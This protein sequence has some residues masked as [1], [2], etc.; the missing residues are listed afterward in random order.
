MSR[1]YKNVLKIKDGAYGPERRKNLAKEI[2]KDSS[3]LPN[4]LEYKDIDEE[5]CRWV[6]ED[7]DISFEG[8]RVPTISLFSNQRFSEYMQSWQNVDDKKNLLLNF[9]TI[10]R[11]NNPKAGTIVGQTRNIPGEPTFLMKRVEAIDNAGRKYY[12]DYR[13]KQPISVDLI[14]TVSIVTSKYELINEFNILMNDKFKSI[15][16]YIRPK[17]HFIPMKINDI[18]DK[19]EY[20]IDNRQYYSQSYNITVMAYIMTEDS[21]I[22]EERPELK[23]LGFEGDRNKTSYAE[24]EELPCG[25]K[26]ESSD[27]YIPIN[28]TIH[29]GKCDSGYKFIIDEYF[30][31]KDITLTNV[32]Y[33]KIFV[34]DEETILD[35]N[36]K[37]KPNDE[38]KIKGLI[39]FKTS[40]DSV[41]MVDGFKYSD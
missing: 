26:E 2:L 40:E 14:Y 36:F 39:R 13:V 10:S 11:E 33:F 27:N 1:E 12:I 19:S 31:A 7:L 3:P 29:F 34:N 9:K 28:L 23:F 15:D 16:C 4:P 30:Q 24:I 25:E 20:S 32:R 17:G 22:V 37:V 6:E 5:F 8:E 35:E 21:F 41:I 38:I 18:S